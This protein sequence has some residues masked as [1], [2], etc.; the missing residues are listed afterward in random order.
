MN[1]IIT[2]HY[3]PVNFQNFALRM[4]ERGIRVLGIGQEPYDQLGD[5][6]RAALTEY[7][8]VDDMED[9]E[10]V[11]RA[12]AFLYYKH[13]KIS[14]LE[15]HNEHWLPLDAYVRRALNIKGL[16]PEDLEKTKYK[17]AMK[18]YF[19]SAGVPVLA[20]YVVKNEAEA[21]KA[22]RDLSYPVVA[23]PDS[24]VGTGGT[25]RIEDERDLENF[26]GVWYQE[27][28]YFIEPFISDA[29]LITY[30]G[31]VDFDGD[32]IFET[33]FTYGRPTLEYAEEK[34]DVAFT[35]TPDIDPILRD[36]GRAAVKSFGMRGRFFHIEFFKKADG[37]YLALEYN[38]RPGGG[39]TIDVY[40]HA[41][42]IDLYDIYARMV[43]GEKLSPLGKAKHY[44]IG[45]SQR[46]IYSYAHYE[47]AIRKKL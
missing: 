25:Y 17:S 34:Y 32:I 44:S 45:L 40:N 22:I 11:A 41:F 9:Y 23:K 20:G 31:L 30:D 15:S 3:F 4:A 39:N 16:R 26:L 47:E 10:E 38:N 1:F 33:S 14:G 37:T 6:L 29:R 24:G 12:A 28:P 46:D 5:D 21:Q 43:A 13:G 35:V 2:S 36:Y 27:T 7:F 18:K 8:R 19:K 42:E